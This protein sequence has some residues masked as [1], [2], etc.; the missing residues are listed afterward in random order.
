MPLARLEF[1]RPGR[2]LFKLALRLCICAALAAGLWGRVAPPAG[3]ATT[4]VVNSAGDGADADTADGLCADS[5]GNCTLRAAIQQANATPGADTVNFRIGT[6]PQTITPGSAL[7]AVNEP[8]T[9]DATTQP[10]FA[11][12]PLVVLSG[13]GAPFSNGL[14]INVGPSTVRGLVVNGF[15]SVGIRLSNGV[16]SVIAGNYIGTDAVGAAAVGNGVG[17]IVI[18]ASG[19]RIGGTTASDRNVISGNATGVTILGSNS[20]VQGNYIGV[21][22][23]GSSPL[24]NAGDGVSIRSTVILSTGTVVSD[25][26]DN[27]VGGTAAGQA[28]VIAH[29]GGSGIAV[30]EH[31]HG[32]VFNVANSFRGN[33]LYSNGLQGISLARPVGVEESNDAADADDGPNGLQNYPVL[34]S[35][36][37][38][39]GGTVVV[40]SLAAKPDTTFALDFYASSACDGSGQGEGQAYL[41]AASVTTAASGDA[42]FSEFV[43]S[44][45]PALPFVTATA[46]DAAGNTSEF[47]PCLNASAPP[48]VQFKRAAYESGEWVPGMIN[49]T[50]TRTVGS[51]AGAAAVDYATSDGT[52]KAGLDYV[53]TSGTVSFAP[54]ELTKSF[55]VRLINDATDEDTQAFSVTL[56]NPTGGVSLG[57]NTTTSVN[58]LD[59]DRMP[60]A[61]AGP[62]LVVNEGST[63]T[64]QA[65]FSILI[66]R[67]SDKP[68]TV[69][70]STLDGTATSPQDFEAAS[71]EATFAPGQTVV[72]VSVAVRA[73]TAPEFQENFFLR[74][75]APTEDGRGFNSSVSCYI[76]DDDNQPGIHLSAARY[77][78][79]EG[80]GHLDIPVVRRGDTSAA[81]SVNYRTAAHSASVHDF[82]P[83][84]GRLDFA[85][86]EAE[87]SFVVLVNDDAFVED[88]EDVGVSIAGAALGGLGFE[89]ARVQITSD[90]AAPPT[91]SNNPIDDAGFF[92]RQHYHDFLAR[93]PDP[94]GFAFWTGQIEA[95]G[96]DAECRRA[97]RAGVSSAF[98]LSI[99]FQRTGYQ[100]FRVHAA[101]YP[102]SY[103]SDLNQRFYQLAPLNLLFT[104]M[105][106]IQEGVIV[107]QTGWDERLREH[108]L[109]FAR[110]WVES[111]DFKAQQPADMAAGAYVD[112]LFANAG[113]AP[114]AGER[115]AALAAFGA[116][117]TEGRAAA[118]LSVT[119]GRP[120]YNRQ[121]NAAFVVMQYYG[122]LRRGPN[123]APDFSFAG[124]DFWLAKLDAF[125]PPGE[126]VR[127]D[128]VA[129]ERAERAEMARAF[130]ESDEY[131]A[132]FG[133]P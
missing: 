52:A 43:S 66:G 108:T 19:T 73:D 122:Y 96:A 38:S 81:V 54:G 130:V 129:A 109:G 103:N 22:A 51:P 14:N 112:K 62:Y 95:C 4:F 133:M 28:N 78:V 75:S 99:E 86:G 46:T 68:I 70:Y 106:K 41:G 67:A 92:V 20:T 5:G 34:D 64:T 89:E 91:A 15:L 76:F 59:D 131:R 8:L 31:N 57:G 124:F 117:G 93:E 45:P 119:D 3:A 116:G 33:S 55:N 125:S 60:T 61:F 97:R 16:G 1:P 11:G 69:R 36:A 88:P 90:D 118:L 56:N 58:I 24:P 25:A 111:A 94:A 35:Y 84:T 47:S 21:A 83:T 42:Q 105:A 37:P 74:V 39:G 123:E 53:A 82:T 7:P 44:V 85:P 110:S 26:H 101:T 9:I 128:S 12:S 87:K 79:A 50:V 107:G 6:G 121:Y 80:A 126:D 13:A 114:G 113:V 120:V 10:G 40:G 71:G 98:F 48:T 32:G 65:V 115:E 63:G 104:N 2:R 30:S 127:D 29:N 132:R 17:V 23:D 27:A 18:N 72:N 49:V 100:V 102:E 77:V